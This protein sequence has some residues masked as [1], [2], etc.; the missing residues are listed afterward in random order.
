MRNTHQQLARN[1]TTISR[2]E[3]EQM[4]DLKSLREELQH[5]DERRSRTA[6]TAMYWLSRLAKHRANEAQV[7]REVVWIATRLLTLIRTR[8][9][10]LHDSNRPRTQSRRW[11]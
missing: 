10:R 5:S 11:S 8:W 3:H 1:T 6:R 9:A 4:F 7:P 2:D